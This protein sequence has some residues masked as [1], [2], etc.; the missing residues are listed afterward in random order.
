M[1]MISNRPYLLRAFF[2]WIIDSNCTPILVLDATNP[3]CRIPEA[4]IDDGEIVF[5]I[6]PVAVRDL[7]LTNQEIKFNASFSG[8]NHLIS[9]P[10]GAILAIYADENGEGLYLD[11]EAEEEAGAATTSSKPERVQLRGIDGT[12]AESLDGFPLEDVPSPVTT[13]KK[14]VLTLVE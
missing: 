10:V 12:N 11:A 5:N 1:Q 2:Q 3:D 4:Y 14:P 6:S 13:H 7:K 8:V 9:A